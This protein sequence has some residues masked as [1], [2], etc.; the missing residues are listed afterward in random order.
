M[1][2]NLEKHILDHSARTENHLPEGFNPSDKKNSHFK[3]SIDISQLIVNKNC[4]SQ[5]HI[6]KIMNDFVDDLM[7]Y[8]K[9]YMV[10][11]GKNRAKK[12][13][14]FNFKDILTAYHNSGSDSANSSKYS[15]EPHIHFLADKS[16]RLGYGYSYLQNA[17][18]EISAKHGLTF[19]F[20]E[21][22][23]FKASP[24][25]QQKA[26][27]FTWFVKGSND[28][29]FIKSLYNGQMDKW[30]DDFTKHYKESG[31]LQY[32]IKGFRDVQ[33]RLKRLG[34]NYTYMNSNIKEAFPLHLTDEQIKSLK[35]I[36]EGNKEQLYK[37]LS[38]RSNKIGR[39]YIEQMHGFDN[40]VIEE[41]QNRGV[42]LPKIDLDIE[43]I[44]LKIQN[45][46]QNKKDYSK[47]INYCYERDFKEALSFA[48]N[49]K[50]LQ[51]IM[52]RHL[53]YKNFK[54][55]QKTINKK[56]SRVGFSF[57]NKNGKTVDVYF[58]RINIT[59][60]EILNLLK[61]NFQEKKEL[62]L[63]R[64]NR[65]LIN[66]KP[67]AATRNMNNQR[68]HE[69]YKFST[70]YD[71]SSFYIKELE[72][73]IEF[74][75][76]GTFI[77]DEG[78]RLLV[79]AQKKEDLNENVKLLLDIAE[80]KGWDIS[81]LNIQGTKEFKLSVHAEIERRSQKRLVVKQ[82][83][84][85]ND[86]I[87]SITDTFITDEDKLKAFKDM[88]LKR[89]KILQKEKEFDQLFDI[90]ERAIKE[91]DI[92]KLTETYRVLPADFHEETREKIV[93]YAKALNI[94][95]Y[96]V[97]MLIGHEQGLKEHEIEIFRD[98]LKALPNYDELFLEKYTQEIS[99]RL[100]DHYIINQDLPENE[101]E[102][103]LKVIGDFEEEMAEFRKDF[104]DK[105]EYIRLIEDTE[106]Y[107]NTGAFYSASKTI[108]QLDEIDRHRYKQKYDQYIDI[109][110]ELHDFEALKERIE[111]ESEQRENGYFADLAA[112]IAAE[113]E[114][115]Q[116]QEE[117]RALQ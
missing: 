33:H 2:W 76:K 90:R 36:R 85:S 22:V 42:S 30:L 104:I 108:N 39:A 55:K 72:N 17:L 32:Y 66:Y 81:K 29:K 24:K 27:K 93:H 86:D 87:K 110:E 47:S 44:N 7:D 79:K 116:K 75:K 103:A 38:D 26:K 34:Q 99:S 20:Q 105:K 35:T 28:K 113:N 71:L 58:N 25:L 115:V 45:K 62:D 11:N 60:E 59:R 5:A 82:E 57:E 12:E 68:F 53:G 102:R 10:S 63:E 101:L 46:E 78:S 54:F 74:K 100:T 77:L 13:I 31:N 61:K 52:S 98:D 83:L 56:R 64:L 106:A 23:P 15:V 107:L 16:K 8:E 89:F 84:R 9:K 112:D 41:L 111:M 91:S 49:E 88:N 94:T 117:S 37:L 70:D 97:D 114:A 19:H 43:R 4:K 18:K 109:A 69:I 1:S 92:D 40:I 51:T 6:D 80:A 73:G 21:E 96:D 65:H 14:T 48:K 3:A 67:Q 50:E 95:S